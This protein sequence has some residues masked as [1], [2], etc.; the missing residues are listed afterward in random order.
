[1]WGVVVLAVT[2][3]WFKARDANPESQPT[4]RIVAYAAS[5][6]LA[7]LG[8]VI[9]MVTGSPSWYGPGMVFLVVVFM[10]F[11]PRNG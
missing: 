9:W 8:G 5:E 3:L 11:N 10:L 2:F 6:G 4:Y 1:L 7:L